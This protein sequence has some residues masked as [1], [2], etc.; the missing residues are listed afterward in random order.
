LENKRMGVN[1]NAPESALHVATTSAADQSR[2]LRMA[3]HSAD[4]VGAVIAGYKSRNATIG[5]HTVVQS[6]DVI[7][8]FGAFASDGSAWVQGGALRFE[9]DGTPGASDMPTRLLFMVTADG[10]SSP[11]EAGRITNA[12]RWGIGETSPDGKLHIDQSD[13][14]GAIPDLVLEQQDVDVAFIKFVGSGTNNDITRSI[15][16]DG[17]YS[18]YAVEGF[19]KVYVQDDGNRMTDGNYFIPVC[20]LS[21]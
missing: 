16:D 6:G 12:R 2:N 5:S 18:A 7:A 14:S 10:A 8:T 4:A 21:S 13:A 15:V 19:I 1:I 9:V 20:S 11:T 17:D 3:Q